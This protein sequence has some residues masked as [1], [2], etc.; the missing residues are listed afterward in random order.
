MSTLCGSM[1]TEGETL[2][3][4]VLP[5]R[6]SICPPFVGACQQRER[7]SKFLSYL[8]GA[9]YVHPLWEHVNRGRDTPSFCPTLQVL[10]MS[11]PGDVAD[12]KFG[13]FDKFHDTER[14]F[15][16]CPR[17]VS[18]R[19]PP[20]GKICK[21]ATAPS[22]HTKKLGEILYLFICSFQ[23]CLSWLLCSGVRKFRRD[24]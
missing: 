13:N 3:V 6:C 1:S 14:F 12:V 18:S 21:Y 2:R 5:Y 10:D 17:H 9:R 20:S 4:S 11:T 19:L 23:L 8:T 24:I 22:T 15:I 16:P 7:H